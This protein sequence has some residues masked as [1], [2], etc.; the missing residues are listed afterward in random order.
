[1]IA[2]ETA[3]IADKTHKRL[4]TPPG[5]GVHLIWP[6]LLGPR[7]PKYCLL[8]VRGCRPRF[9]LPRRCVPEPGSW[10]NSWRRNRRHSSATFAKSPICR[11]T[12]NSPT[13]SATA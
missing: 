3:A 11:S 13:D 10:Q 7:R 12:R 9:C 5:D 8:L 6:Y 4:G 1:V 2:A